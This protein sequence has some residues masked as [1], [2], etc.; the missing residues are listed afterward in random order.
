MSWLLKQ[1][2]KGEAWRLSE[3]FRNFGF[4]DFEQLAWMPSA[5]GDEV[6]GLLQ[7]GADIIHV[8]AWARAPVPGLSL[9]TTAEYL[10]QQLAFANSVENVEAD[11]PKADES[12]AVGSNDGVEVVPPWKLIETAS[13]K[14]PLPTEEPP[15]AAWLESLVSRDL[16]DNL[17]SDWD[18]QG[19]Y[20]GKYADD[21]A[22]IWV[23]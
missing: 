4:R 8:P 7:F 22:G 18:Y 9:S 21:G 19:K 20:I 1:V 16:P 17:E 2:P 23:S 12:K 10:D 5:A 6:V 3:Q 11:D 14:R 15:D 13:K